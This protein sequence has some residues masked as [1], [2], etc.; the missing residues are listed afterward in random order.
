MRDVDTPYCAA[1]HLRLL[2]LSPAG[3]YMVRLCL[4]GFW[5]EVIVDDRLPSLGGGQYHQQLAYCSTLRLQ[6]WASIIEK[7]A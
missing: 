5:R 1:A 2:R 6:L 7:A 4:G 3:I